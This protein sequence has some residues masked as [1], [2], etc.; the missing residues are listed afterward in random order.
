MPE[1]V[2]QKPEYEVHFLDIGDADCIAIKYRKDSNSRAYVAL[3]DAGN[4]SDS[5]AIKEF[6]KNRFGTQAIDL[7]VCT[8]PDKDHK[9]GF[10]K[11][12]ED[13]DVTIREF[14]LK[15]PYQFI[16][17]DDFAKMKR[18]DKKLEACRSIYNHPSDSSKNLISLIKQKHN[19][20]GS[21]CQFKDVKQG[22]DYQNIPLRVLGPSED[23]YKEVAVG[24]VGGFAELIDDPSTEAYDEKFVVSDEQAKSVIDKTD[25]ASFTNKGSLILLLTLAPNFKILLAGDASQTSIGMACDQYKEIIGSVFKVPHHG[26]KHNLNTIVIDKLKPCTSIVC[27]AQTRKHPNPAIVSWLSKYGSVF[28]TRKSKGLYYTDKPV[29]DKA[30]PLRKKQD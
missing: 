12:L 16:S 30:E 19:N 22:Q 23:Y 26:S 17:D 20:D 1:T 8:H 21:W 15:D 27:A 6:L 14:W 10:F 4:V 25:D 11:L 13:N 29:V 7:A 3:I 18:A 24:I 28:C 2:L 9:G 5:D